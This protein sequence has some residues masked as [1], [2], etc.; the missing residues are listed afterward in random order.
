[1]LYLDAMVLVAFIDRLAIGHE[2]AARLLARAS[3]PETRVQLVTATLTI[4]EVA[5]VLLEELVTREPF[6]VPR[7]RSQYLGAHP[8]AV[9]RLATSID[10]PLRAVLQLISVEPVVASDVSEMIREM[11]ST[12]LLPRDALHV[13]VMRR[14]GITALVSADQAFDR[15]ADITRFAP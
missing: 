3:E 13:S 14:L 10:E 11:G 15:C 2:S 12:G 7:A 5:F 9:Q 4:D 1:V 8:E 6:G